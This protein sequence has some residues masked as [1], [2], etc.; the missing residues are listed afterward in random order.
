MKVLSNFNL[1]LIQI[2]KYLIFLTHIFFILTS[3]LGLLFYWYPLILLFFA[4]ISWYLNE[5][6]CIITQI[7]DYLFKETIIDVY[8][9]IL[10]KK[11]NNKN[12]YKVP[13]YH[14][15]FV[16]LIF[17]IAFFYYFIYKK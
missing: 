4:I 15:Y 9:K 8:F 6:K 3:I 16:I 5:N 1:I 13:K 2:F 7:E 17:Q 14:R 10:N 11:N 12:R